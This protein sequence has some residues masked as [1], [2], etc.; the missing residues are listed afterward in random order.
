MWPDG[1]AESLEP[2]PRSDWTRICPLARPGAI[3]GKAGLIWVGEQFYATPAD[4]LAEAC[5]M[6]ISRLI[7]TVP[8]N[9][10]LGETWVLLAHRKGI[11]RLEAA[12]DELVETIKWTPAIFSIFKPTAIEYVVKGTETEEEL[13]RLSARN[14]TAVK[15][16]NRLAQR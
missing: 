16:I 13:E 7:S 5:T 8:R 4:F 14:I 11:G 1:R 9:F 3:E 2:C 15:V 10:R 6:G 12:E